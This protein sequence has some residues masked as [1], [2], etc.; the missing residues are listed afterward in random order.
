MKGGDVSKDYLQDGSY[1]LLVLPIRAHV[2][3]KMKKNSPL[4]ATSLFTCKKN[5]RTISFKKN[6][7]LV[8]QANSFAKDNLP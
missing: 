1:V 4:S 3:K 6:H 7:N 8:F 5:N 2:L